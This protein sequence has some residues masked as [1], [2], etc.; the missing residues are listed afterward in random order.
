VKRSSGA[1][2]RW[3]EL[4][5]QAEE[6]EKMASGKDY[7]GPT[8]WSNRMESSRKA[9]ADGDY[10]PSEDQ[11]GTTWWLPI[12]SCRAINAAFDEEVMR[13]VWSAAAETLRKWASRLELEQAL[14]ESK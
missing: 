1:L 9:I 10:R 12:E 7:G 8:Y 5:A 4:M 11:I 2:G 6:L 14:E 3:Q 13:A